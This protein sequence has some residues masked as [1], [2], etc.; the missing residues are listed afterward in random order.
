MAIRTHSRTE[1]TPAGT[2][3]VGGI[4]NGNFDQIEAVLDPATASGN[5][6]FNLIA[7]ALLRVT[8][9]PTDAATIRYS[10][11]SGKFVARP[12]FAILTNAASIAA[13]FAAAETQ[14]VDIA[15]DTTVTFANLSQGRR[16]DLIIVCDATPRA[17]T[18]PA[19]IRWLG[20]APTGLAAGKA[21]RA[22]FY[23]TTG[24]SSGVFAEWDVEP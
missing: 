9:L 21:G 6:W 23:S 10:V 20:T 14:R 3:N 22:R 15:Q 4:I 1:S 16:L 2:A 18:W 5:P 8:G 17:L 24:S 11:A 13:D 12:A 19:S 7:R